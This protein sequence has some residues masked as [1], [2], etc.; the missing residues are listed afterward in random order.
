[1]KKRN[2]ITIIAIVALIAISVVYLA[3]RPSYDFFID[4]DQYFG[5]TPSIAQKNANKACLDS[6]SA[7]GYVTCV[8]NGI[9]SDGATVSTYCT[10][11]GWF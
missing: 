6:W 5:G 3:T 1:M 8:A 9:S 2:V 11:T 7:S 4:G 10:C